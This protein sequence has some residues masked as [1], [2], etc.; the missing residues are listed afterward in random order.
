MNPWIHV[1]GKELSL[2]R[3][4]LHIL[5]IVFFVWKKNNYSYEIHSKI[6]LVYLIFVGVVYSTCCN[7]IFRKHFSFSNPFLTRL[8][9]PGARNPTEVNA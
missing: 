4:I 5:H 3:V 9:R 8:S 6:F 1:T 2:C 7:P